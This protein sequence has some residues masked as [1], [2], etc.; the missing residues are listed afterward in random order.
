MTVNKPVD[1]DAAFNVNVEFTFQ[2]GAASNHAHVRFT[3]EPRNVEVTSAG[4][5]IFQS[6]RGYEGQWFVYWT[7]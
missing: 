7:P 6:G 4:E 1:A 3:A 5:M 2:P